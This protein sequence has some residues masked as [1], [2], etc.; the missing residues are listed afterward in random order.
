M[1]PGR[2]Y[3][4]YEKSITYS[5]MW[6]M[7]NE[8]RVWSEGVTATS[9]QPGATAT[10]SFTG[11]SVSWIGCEKGSAGGVADV[12]ID[13]VLVKQGIRLTQTYPVEGYQMTVFRADGLT[14]GA[15]TIMVQV[16]NTDGSYV[17]VDA[18]DTH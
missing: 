11:T 7:D 18:F 5:G 4:E 14:N 9:N 12:Y 10:F 3:E 13:G 1:T 15:H 8:A 6:T 2:R 17:V 16:M